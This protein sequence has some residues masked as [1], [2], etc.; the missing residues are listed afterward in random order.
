MEETRETSCLMEKEKKQYTNTKAL[1]RIAVMR[2]AFN[3]IKTMK[4]E[5]EDL[6]EII[7]TLVFTSLDI[8]ENVIE[9]QDSELKWC[10]KFFCEEIEKIEPNYFN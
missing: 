1:I 2:E 6:N 9:Q 8:F 5:K 3:N 7:D 4:L 10:K